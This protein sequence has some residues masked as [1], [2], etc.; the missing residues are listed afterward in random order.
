MKSDSNNGDYIYNGLDRA[1]NSKG[2]ELDNVVPCC[3]RCNRAKN[4]Y[5]R[6]DFL[7]WI[8]KVYKYSV[9]D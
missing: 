8:E 5:N 3:G 9:G 6:D 4:A 7:L 1:D 2:Y